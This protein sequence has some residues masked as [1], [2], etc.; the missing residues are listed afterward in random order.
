MKRHA[1]VWEKM[2]KSN[3]NDKRF[4]E[5]KYLEKIFT[6]NIYDKRLVFQMYKERYVLYCVLQYKKY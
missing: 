5:I 1:T 2:L 6:S 4:V 3:M